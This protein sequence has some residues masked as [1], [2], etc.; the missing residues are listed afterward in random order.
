MVGMSVHAPA[1]VPRASV[2]VPVVRLMSVN[3]RALVHRM[4]VNVPVEGAPQG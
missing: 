1:L 3:A 4:S 2:N